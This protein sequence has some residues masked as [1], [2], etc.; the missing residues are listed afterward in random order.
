MASFCAVNNL[1][2]AY[3]T[4]F[5]RAEVAIFATIV[6]PLTANLYAFALTVD[7]SKYFFDFCIEAFAFNCCCSKLETDPAVSFVLIAYSIAFLLASLV[8]LFKIACCFATSPVA[9]K[10]S[11]KK[12]L[13]FS[14]C[15]AKFSLSILA[16]LKNDM[17]RSPSSVVLNIILCYNA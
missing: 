8:D 1:L 3:T 6:I 9:L 14:S 11:V 7:K 16:L 13:S 2:N 10:Y 4:P 17:I 5:N 12:I 15:F